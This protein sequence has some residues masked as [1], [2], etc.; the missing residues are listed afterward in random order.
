MVDRATQQ[1]TNRLGCSEEEWAMRVQLA[2]CYRIFSHMG[3]A[4]LIYN[5]ITAKVPGPDHHFLINPYG[6]HYDEVCASNLVKIDLKGN[7]VGASDYPVNP[8]GFVIHSAIHEARPDVVCIAHTHT[9]DGMAVA[10]REGGLRCDNFYSCLLAGQVAYHDF[11]G[12]T[13][14]PEEKGRLIASLG[15]K[16]HLVLRHHGLLTCGPDIAATFQ[17]MWAL[18]RSCE[19]EVAAAAGGAAV[20]PI[21]EEIASFS[22]S[23]VKVMAMGGNWGQLEFAAMTRRID[24]IDPSYKI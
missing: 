2:A 10:C 5:H 18:Q 9:T 19:I 24:R 8:A 1:L 23:S 22:A 17:F 3:W 15:Q 11:E 13:V 21:A 14:H 7:V 6:L 20:L 12:I 4:E 16:N